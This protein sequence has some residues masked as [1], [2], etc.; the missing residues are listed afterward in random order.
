MWKASDDQWPG[1]WSGGTDITPQMVTEWYEREG[2]LNVQVVETA[3]GSKIV[4]YCS[5]NERQ[6]QKGVGYIGLLNV[7][8]DYQKKSLA[9]RLLQNGIQ[10]CLDLDFHLLTLGTWS[11]N[12]KA[13]PLYKKVGFCW[14]PDTSVWMLNFI[15]AI[16]TLPCAQP[17][18][19]R[20]DWYRT[21]KR[22]LKQVEDDDRWEGMKVFTYHFEEDGEA[23]TVWADRESWRI[24]AVETDAFFAGAMVDN[25]EPP[26]GI[27]TELRWRFTNKRSE[28]V[29]ISLIGAGT[30]YIKLDHRQ[31]LAVAAGETVE[32]SAPVDVALDAPAVK[33]DQPVP[34]LRTIFIIDGEV[35]E[36]GTGV[37]PQPA[38]AV[39]THPEYVTLSPGVSK[40]VSLQLKSYLREEAVATVTVTP[41]PGL[42]VGWTSSQVTLPAKGWAG[43]EITLSAEAGGVYPLHV[44]VGFSEGATKPER[45]AIFCMPPGGV[46]VDLGEKEARLENCETRLLARKHG[47]EVAIHAVTEHR[48][49]GNLRER[50]GPPFYPSEFSEK[51]FDIILSP[52]SRGAAIILKAD[53]ETYPG[54]VLQRTVKLGGGNLIELKTDFVNQGTEAHKLQI[55]HLAR[56]QGACHGGAA[57]K[58]GHRA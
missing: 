58:A 41:A 11:G 21:Y 32:L 50:L 3:D 12:L 31:T 29:S 42:S 6:E 49:L 5:F 22:E 57:A 48:F 2:M 14:V 45:L 55:V 40:K 36:L 24:T 4:G 25:I 19:S 43:A 34:A 9:R 8:P 56:Y 26:K 28:Q 37:R 33:G 35:L 23:L 18:F 38:V 16:L 39:S 54:L 53:S 47:G 46:L 51:D 30:E 7:Q 17:F 1:T 52:G 44:T 27:V 20:H 10:R 15:P 13:M